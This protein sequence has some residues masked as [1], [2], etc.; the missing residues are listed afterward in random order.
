LGVTYQA[1][2]DE[3]GNRDMIR[4]SNVPVFIKK[5]EAAIVNMELEANQVY[6]GFVTA[7][8]HRLLTET[9][10]WSG[11]AVANWNVS[12]NGSDWSVNHGLKTAAA[13]DRSARAA[14]KHE[15]DTPYGPAVSKGDP[16]AIMMSVR[17]N[18]MS[19][20]MTY[21]K[22][23]THLCNAA[24]SLD[25]SVYIQY[26]EE[27]TNDFLR[28]INHPGHMVERVSTT[29]S[30]FGLLTETQQ[31]ALRSIVPGQLTNPGFGL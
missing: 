13:P 20:S 22:Y 31:Q 26:L 15:W 24:E 7:V 12:I 29:A 28:P 4:F 23:R 3:F 5:L 11:N 17:R 19:L 14:V 1:C 16:R 25:N 18:S 2:C 30:S 9:P 21:L 27:N 10:Q 8:F 6:R